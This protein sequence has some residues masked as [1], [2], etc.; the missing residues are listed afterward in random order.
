MEES[1]DQAAR[2]ARPSA[3]QVSRLIQR[4]SGARGVTSPVA[5]VSSMGWNPA[6]APAPLSWIRAK[7]TYLPS[8]LT[9]AR[10]S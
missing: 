8:G 7:A 1:F 5:T 9:T 10:R 4:S 3:R 6:M 2:T